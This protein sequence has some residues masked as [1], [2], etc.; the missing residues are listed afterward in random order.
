M[1]RLRGASRATVVQGAVFGADTQRLTRINDFRMEAVPDYQT[2][3]NSYFK[4]LAKMAPNLV[5]NALH[6]WRRR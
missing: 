2:P 5:R 4:L 6:V 1:V 3:P